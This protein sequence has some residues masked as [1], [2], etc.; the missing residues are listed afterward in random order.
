[1][2]ER[3]SSLTIE[4]FF[5]RRDKREREEQEGE[6]LEIFK[7]STKVERSP[8]GKGERGWMEVVKEMRV[9]FKEVM[10]E[11]NEWREGKEEMKKWMEDMRKR[12][13]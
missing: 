8:V 9:G 6:E 12:W 1:M 3:S 13:D 7:K 2:R 5:M 11:V 10:K 4:K